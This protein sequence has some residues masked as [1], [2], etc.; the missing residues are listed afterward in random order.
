MTAISPPSSSS[1]SPQRRAAS[2]I[3]PGYQVGNRAMAPT[4]RRFTTA[5]PSQHDVANRKRIKAYLDSSL[6]FPDTFGEIGQEGGY[7]YASGPKKRS[8]FAL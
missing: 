1:G 8:E 4:S 2:L 6:C 7:A 5:A 3:R